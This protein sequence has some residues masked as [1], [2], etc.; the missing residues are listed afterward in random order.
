LFLIDQSDRVAISGP[1][2]PT[3]IV[4]DF[5]ALGDVCGVADVETVVGTTQNID[6]K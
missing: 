4:V 3:A 1:S 5:D 6:E 2:G